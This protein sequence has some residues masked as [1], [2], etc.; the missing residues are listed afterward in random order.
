MIIVFWMGPA[1]VCNLYRHAKQEEFTIIIKNRRWNI[2]VIKW[3]SKK[4][5]LQIV[6]KHGLLTTEGHLI[7]YIKRKVGKK[8]QKQPSKPPTAGSSHTKFSTSLVISILPLICRLISS[9]QDAK[10]L[11]ILLLF[12]C[13]FFILKIILK[14]LFT[15]EKTTNA[16]LQN[17]KVC[18]L[19][20]YRCFFC[21]LYESK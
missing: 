10:P 13:F 6:N 9:P 11:T 17:R 15:Y 20:Q 8:N 1:Q 18:I 12:K 5:Y 3:Q 14:V 2:P 7:F 21:Y 4:P 16:S 19:S